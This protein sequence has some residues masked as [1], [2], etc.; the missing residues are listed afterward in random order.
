MT[1][2]LTTARVI[3]RHF[4]TCLAGRRAL[5]VTRQTRYITLLQ[6][7]TCYYALITHYH[8]ERSEG[9]LRL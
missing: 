5:S 8:P 1:Y 3:L 9:S 2:C 4:A 7:L 6:L